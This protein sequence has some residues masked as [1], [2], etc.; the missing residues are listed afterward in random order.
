MFL[1]VD[2]STRSLNQGKVEPDVQAQC[3]CGPT[4][5]EHGA[6]PPGA[7][8]SLQQRADLVWPLDPALLEEVGAFVQSLWSLWPTLTLV[9]Y[10]SQEACGCLG[11]VSL[12]WFLVYSEII[13]VLGLVLLS[14]LTIMLFFWLYL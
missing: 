9:T 7:A 13:G 5:T 11:T 12:E 3:S 14:L 6:E 1:S 2:D 4:R 8:L 10:S